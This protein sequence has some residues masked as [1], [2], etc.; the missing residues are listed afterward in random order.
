M[1]LGLPS[2]GPGPKGKG[3]LDI[4]LKKTGGE[5]SRLAE[6]RITLNKCNTCKKFSYFSITSCLPI[7]LSAACSV[8]EHN[9]MIGTILFFPFYFYSHLHLE[10]ALSFFFLAAFLT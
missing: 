3:S 10:I 5:V 6:P 9:K 7:L 4:I 1:W 8:A 2:L